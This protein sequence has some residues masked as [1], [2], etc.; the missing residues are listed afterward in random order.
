MQDE[1]SIIAATKRWVEQF[2]IRHQICP[3]AGKVFALEQIHYRVVFEEKVENCLA[4]FLE[5]CQ[6]LDQTPAID[7]S[8][9]VFPHQFDDFH[10]Y[11]DFTDLA[12]AL[13]IDK[14]YEGVYQIATFHPNYLFAQSSEDD[15]ANYTNRSLYPMVHLLREESVGKVLEN[16][17][18]PEA[19]PERNIRFAR[20]QG[21]EQMKKFREDCF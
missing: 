5:E 17:E 2:I 12:Q 10:A 9:I 19:I 6:R 4:I 14:E 7:T 13:L 18:D 21:L 8:L 1:Q 3:F 16:I 15:P 20:S 11:L